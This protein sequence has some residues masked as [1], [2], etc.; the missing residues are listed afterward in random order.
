ML[1]KLTIRDCR[2]KA[3]SKRGKLIDKIYFNSGFKMEWECAEGHTWMALGS[4]VVK[5][6]P[7]TWCKICSGKAKKDIS[8]LQEKAKNI[9]IF[10]ISKRYGGMDKKYVWKC[11]EGH[12]WRASASKI[13][14]CGRRC[15]DC[16]I[17]RRREVICLQTGV[18]YRSISNAAR[19]IGVSPTMVSRVV[20]GINKQTK[21]LTFKYYKP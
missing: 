1:N 11:K 7:G 19:D 18:V 16:S 14:N 13:I 4:S 3:K 5:R 21:N 9:G 6:K 17:G 2:L 8:Y 20:L 10:L 12:T 15:P